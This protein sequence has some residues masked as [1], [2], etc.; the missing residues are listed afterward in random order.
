MITKVQISTPNQNKLAFGNADSL[1]REFQQTGKTPAFVTKF[2]KEM[3][4]ASECR[5]APLNAQITVE[6]SALCA[7]HF[8]EQRQ[9]DYG[10]AEDLL[11]AAERIRDSLKLTLA[12]KGRQLRELFEE[13]CPDTPK[14]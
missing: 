1:F 3:L 6:S 14:S 8:H 5:L 10:F 13:F 11:A 2:A 4:E 9:P 12:Q 7:P